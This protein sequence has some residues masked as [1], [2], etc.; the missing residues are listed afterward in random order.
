MIQ[1]NNDN[2]EKL[3]II[4]SYWNN[5]NDYWMLSSTKCKYY[6]KPPNEIEFLRDIVSSHTPCIING[7]IDDWPALK[8]WNYNYLINKTNN[9][10]VLINFTHD[11]DAD[12]IK[13][14]ND[15]YYFIYPAEVKMKFNNFINML[16][17]K[18]YD[19]AI[20]YLS[21]QDDNLRKYFNILL[22]DITIGLPLANI[23]FKDPYIN[24]SLTAINLWIGD[25]RSV[26]SLHKDFYENF[27]CVIDGEKTFTLLPPGDIAFMNEK[28]Y[29]TKS[30]KYKKDNNDVDN[31]YRIKKDDIIISETSN[32]KVSW[33]AKDPNNNS[34]FFKDCHPYQIT[35]KKGETLYLPAMWYHRVSQTVDTIAVNFWYEQRFDHR[36]IQYQLARKVSSLYNKLNLHQI[37]WR[38]EQNNDD[39]DDNDNENDENENENNHDNNDDNNNNDNNDDDNDNNDK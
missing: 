14:I 20:P 15:D 13:F 21:Q 38:K 17:N 10:D 5:I 23:A 8:N 34:S 24:D 29:K 37:D 16:Q 31:N 27:Y 33:I 26:S 32:N 4:N 36:Y 19:D 11:G 22:N 9:Q 30:Y 28:E 3:S 35:L 7:L 25:E 6:E 2:N 12:S 39:Y 18:E 1:N